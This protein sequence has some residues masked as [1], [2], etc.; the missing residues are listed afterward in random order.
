[1]TLPELLY[2]ARR[3]FADELTQQMAWV[4]ALKE[5][6]AERL[7]R[8]VRIPPEQRDLFGWLALGEMISSVHRELAADRLDFPHVAEHVRDIQANEFR[9]WQV[10]AELQQKYLAILDGE[11][12]WDRQTARLYAI[13]HEECSTSCDVILI[14][15]ADMNRTQRSM[16]DQV[17]D[18]V[19]AL[20]FA[21]EQLAGRFDEHGC[22]S[23]NAW[24]DV[25]L[26]L[27]ED[28]IRMA[29]S[30]ADQAA[31]V[32]ASLA[33][34]GG[35]FSG[36][37]I[38]VGVPDETLVPV[39]E[40]QLHEC[41]LTARYGVG[42]PLGFTGPVRLLKAVSDFLEQG[43][44][45]SLRNLVRHP[46]MEEWCSRQE[47]SRNWQ[48]EL[49][50]YLSTYLPGT[51]RDMSAAARKKFS[52]A[53][54]VLD[55][56]SQLLEVLSGPAAASRHWPR[57]VAD[58]I[59]EIY[60]E[61]TVDL[62]NEEDRQ[63]LLA[64][65]ALKNELQ[66]LGGLAESLQPQL[67][68]AEALRLIL[69]AA[70]SRTIPPPADPTAIE[71]LGWLELPLDDAPCLI[72]TGFNEGFV[73]SSRNSDLF[74]PNELRHQLGLEDNHRRYARDAYALELLIHSRERLT[75]IAGR[76]S[77]EGD[78]LSPSRLLMACADDE[79]PS[80]ILRL[81]DEPDSGQASLPQSLLL[82]PGGGD[83]RFA[84]PEPASLDEE[85]QSMRVT[86]FR[87][88]LA[89][90]YR[91][92]LKHR[93]KL[94]QAGGAA[95][96]LDAGL[97]GSLVHEVLKDFGQGSTR[98]SFDEREIRD[99]L[100]EALNV[101]VRATFGTSPLP[102]V[103]VQVEQ[104]R[105]RLHAFAGWQARWAGA[106]W[107]ISEHVERSFRNEDAPF[108][109]DGQPMYLRGQID[110]ID[111]NQLT[112]QVAIL[113]YKTGDSGTAPKKTHRN[114]DGSW[115]DLQLP[116]YRHLARNLLQAE[117]VV[118]GYIALPK[119]VS[120][121]GDLLADWTADDLDHADQTAAE[122]IRGVR[123][124][125]FWPRSLDPPPFSEEYAAICLDGLYS[126]TVAA[127]SLDEDGQIPEDGG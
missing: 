59:A 83:S 54:V 57:A 66:T 123:E 72:V 18:H 113:D 35:S 23:P 124:Q 96:E 109:V 50:E 24:Q 14:G 114:S 73:P 81:F 5:L 110:R 28:I 12:L 122:V 62:A 3:P 21:P 22:L 80:R 76:R 94:K 68:G 20:I 1:G 116:L 84:V 56:I 99:Y 41:S 101:Y 103:A 15:T 45:R 40:Q 51:V 105:Y 19:T 48:S 10:L 9:R 29:G 87:D 100:D 71:L 70:G 61:R 52:A 6:P 69:T 43:N 77:A 25:L 119:D 44:S 106:G 53:A 42:R 58:L 46:A 39:L 108:D 102:A 7:T 90:P 34:T 75:L 125:R 120:R 11:Q 127:G 88:Y 104:I 30:P 13:D 49:E 2:E 32:V 79:L 91:Y 111:I 107:T 97:F 115:K 121:T 74:L 78:P 36:D 33:E 95:D 64:C 37:Q 26:P 60:G 112:G 117:E 82:Q 93:L 86:E 98:F 92:Y 67:A 118:L 38:T 89:C 85:V 63:T 65:R 27:S 16:L 8:L 17:A 31:A 126:H 4:R 55:A 47:H